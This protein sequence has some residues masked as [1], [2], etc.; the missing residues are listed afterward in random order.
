M[1]LRRATLT[2]VFAVA[3]ACAP[4]LGLASPSPSGASSLA[5]H[6]LTIAAVPNPIIAG[7]SL[8][9]YGQLHGADV[10][11]QLIKLFVR[12]GS[13][14]SFFEIGATR[15]DTTGLYEFTR[16][17]GVVQTNRSWFVRGPGGAQSRTT[18]EGVA[19]LVSI[20]AS[21]TLATTG[22]SLV[23]SGRVALSHPGE[24]VLLQQQTELSGGGWRTIA[25][26]VTGP[27]SHFRVTHRWVIPGDYT[28]RAVLPADANNREG[29]SDSE[30]VSIQ[31]KQV[32]SFT[33]STSSPVV[34]E[35][36]SVVLSGVLYRA[37]STTM[38]K[39]A[40]QVTLYARPAGGTFAA[41][42][43]TVTGSDGNYKFSQTPVHDQVYEVEVSLDHARATANLFEGVQDALTLS[44]GG[45]TMAEVGQT[46]S[47]TGTVAPDQ[48]GHVIW[49]Q[50]LGADGHWHNVVTSSVATGSVYSLHYTFGG[51][52]T[53]EFRAA[54]PGGPEN[55]GGA[56]TT[57][58]FTV[59]GVV[60]IT[61]LPPAS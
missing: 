32:P 60:P 17:V 61:S 29:D 41:V 5:G 51:V 19:A 7:E 37:G 38:V 39:P 28:V 22:K 24:K 45:S 18:N 20:G 23:F 43:T 16:A 21:A 8:L 6:R 26:V 25:T 30:T 31:Q 48:V 3:L 34:I 44:T 27:R 46:V 10:A 57:V 1:M 35:G 36:Q 49:L 11:N 4:L 53:I 42:G 55:A 14:A 54:M 47:I 56:S 58:T 40:A 59:T 15:T 2:G 52:G 50:R 9:I 13:A 12:R 33:I